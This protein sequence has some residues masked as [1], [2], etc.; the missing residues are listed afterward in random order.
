[1]LGGGV[2]KH[3]DANAAEA[4][5]GLMGS[6]M[7]EF[8]TTNFMEQSALALFESRTDFAVNVLEVWR[9]ALGQTGVDSSIVCIQRLFGKSADRS[10]DGPLGSGFLSARIKRSLAGSGPKSGLSG[11]RANQPLTVPK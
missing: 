3:S 8:G 7:R 10:A 11:S 2:S 4:I 1:V 9:G 6:L 5:A